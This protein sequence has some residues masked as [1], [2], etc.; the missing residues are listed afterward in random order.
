MNEEALGLQKQV[1]A[2]AMIHA[3][4]VIE[5][6][7]QSAECHTEDSHVLGHL[8]QIRAW[9]NSALSAPQRNC[10]VFTEEEQYDRHDKY[11]NSQ[12]TCRKCLREDAASMCIS[13]F[14][15]WAQRPYESE[16]KNGPQE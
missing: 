11:C 15:K 3:L 4:K 14:A 2:A 12:P 16:A 8:N 6:Y 7:A 1:N 9:V 13:C 5:G 10:D